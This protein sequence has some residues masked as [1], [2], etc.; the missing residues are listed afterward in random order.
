MG[1]ALTIE[2]LFNIERVSHLSV[3]PDGRYG[4]ISTKRIDLSEN[5]TTIC[6]YRIDISK[7]TIESVN[8]HEKG[9]SEFSYSGDGEHL[10]FSADGQI[11]ISDNS[12]CG[13]RVLTHGHGGASCPVA[14]KDGR[15]VL[16]TRT[17]Y[18]DSRVQALYEE[19]GK[20]PELGVVSGV[21]H[22]KASVRV[23]DRLMYRHWDSWSE[24]KRNHLY[25]VDVESGEMSDLTS[26]DADVPPIAL[27][28]GCDYSFSPDG[29][30]IVFV[31]NPDEMIARST[32]NS[33]YMM[34]I[35]GVKG[36]TVRRISTTDGCDT[37]PQFISSHEVAYFSML[38]PSCESDRVRLKVYDL[39]SGSTRIYL[40]DFERCPEYFVRYD[41]ESLLFSAQDFAHVSLYRLNLTTGEVEQLTQGRSYTKVAFGG[42]KL[43]AGLESLEAPMEIVLLKHLEHFEPRIKL[44]EEKVTGEEIYQVTKFGD[45][46]SDVEMHRGICTH[47]RYKDEI[48][49]GYIVTP[50]GFDES[51]RYP[52][53]LLIHGGPQGAFL[54]SFHYR[55]NVQMFSARGAVTVFCNPHGSTGYGHALTE[56][57]S[58]HWS[59]E[60]PEAI[61][62][63][64]DHVLKEVPQIDSE[65]L[66][67]AG[68]SFGGYMINW[69]LG[70]TDRFKAF[71]SHDGIFN[72]E[73][74]GYITDELWFCDYEFGGTPY[75]VP[76]SYERHSPHRY[77]K[78]FRTP[79]LVVQGEQ[80]FR[81]FI[82]EGVGLF[83]ALQ[84]MGVES[85]LVYF[86][87][88]GHWVLD[89]ADSC[90]WYDEVV[91][92]LMKHV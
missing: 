44:G 33:I 92:W 26:E 21:C 18:M 43:L 72:T 47:Y 55:W 5:R 11:Y 12:G 17:V 87:N 58:N 28:S 57:I 81:C 73:M 9:A 51:R 20:A 41:E 37:G 61:M 69:L 29:K 31:K 8:L 30:K 50:P 62:T 4:W 86:P 7:G 91:G 35:E 52:M 80:D 1:R 85:R 53:I 89:P 82:S 36:G 38:K 39:E 3:S 6:N 22:P 32:N 76:E 71:V 77:V 74:S 63:F 83:T 79:T 64:V 46:L 27:E 48:L 40:T 19:T 2:D 78:N 15:Y 42:G 54:D 13:V 75:D 60:C 34:D 14:S 24:N 10:F 59:D 88:E 65:R 23:A 16:F 68:A 49:E 66:T 84:Y 70:H 67:A 25:I 56:S 90:V 45:V